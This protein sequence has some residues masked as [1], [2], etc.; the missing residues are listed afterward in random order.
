[1]NKELNK[2]NNIQSIKNNYKEV[3]LKLNK[4]EIEA[5]YKNVNKKA[6]DSLGTVKNNFSY[7]PDEINKANDELKELDKILVNRFPNIAGL[8]IATRLDLLI[9]KYSELTDEAQAL[10]CYIKF[11]DFFNLINSLE[12]NINYLKIIFNKFY[13]RYTFRIWN[14]ERLLLDE[15]NVPED[16]VLTTLEPY[17]YDNNSFYDKSLEMDF[18][19]FIEEIVINIESAI[20]EI[21]KYLK[22]EFNPSSYSN[23]DIIKTIEGII[24]LQ[25]IAKESIKSY[26]CIKENPFKRAIEIEAE[27]K[28]DILNNLSVGSENKYSID[29][30]KAFILTKAP[31]YNFETFELIVP[32]GD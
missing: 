27:V 28:T 2:M 14:L 20:A 18:N 9:E 4:N 32:D 5:L 11:K 24:E 22:V 30:E 3:L 7:N 1:M 19:F 31:S 13:F 15:L 8:G 25:K 17:I 10:I 21:D 23:E 16:I 26:E 6:V 29:K 12:G